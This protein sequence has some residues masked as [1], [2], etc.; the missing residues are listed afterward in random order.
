MEF[1]SFPK[2]VSFYISSPVDWI[3]EQVA[4]NFVTGDEFFLGE[5]K[6]FLNSISILSPKDF[7]SKIKIKSLNPI[8]MRSTADDGTYKLYNP[9]E[10]FS[11]A[12]NKNLQKKWVAF[13]GEDCPY[14]LKIQPIHIKKAATWYGTREKGAVIE[15]W[16][17]IFEL[18]GDPEF[19]KFAYDAGLGER[20]SMGFGIWREIG[21][22]KKNVNKLHIY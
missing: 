1:F 3:L 5:N 13:K 9:G 4:M 15:G 20:T 22:D 19:L 18:S 17:G 16:Q 6:V 7:A 8:A 12:I 21:E 2:K 11:Y 10:R 14:E